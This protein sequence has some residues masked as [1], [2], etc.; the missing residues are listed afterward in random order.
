MRTTVTLD[1]DVEQLLREAAHR[2]RKSFKE[3]LNGALRI[4][5]SAGRKQAPS[6]SFKLKARP[7]HLRAGLDPGGFNKLAD[8]LEVDAFIAK[9]SRL[10]GK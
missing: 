5:L 6:K 4:G 2:S 7:L 8:E 3:T 1:H 9:A 10:R